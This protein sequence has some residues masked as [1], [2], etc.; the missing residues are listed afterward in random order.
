MRISQQFRSYVY[1]FVV[2]VFPSHCRL[3]INRFGG[4]IGLA[5]DQSSS[6]R[7]LQLLH[8]WT[9]ISICFCYNRPHAVFSNSSFDQ[10]TYDMFHLARPLIGPVVRSIGPNNGNMTLSVVNIPPSTFFCFKRLMVHLA[11]HHAGV[12]APAGA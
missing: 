8:R 1:V 10:G 11:F 4:F 5:P 6:L 9:A 7:T 3:I 12:A 2:I